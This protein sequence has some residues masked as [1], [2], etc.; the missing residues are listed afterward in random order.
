MDIL[1]FLGSAR[2]KGNTA[3]VLGWV[4]EE[5]RSLGHSVER[6]NLA[7]KKIS[8]CL[9]C[10]KCRRFPDRL[11]CVQEDDAP[12]ILE[13]QLSADA[14]IYASP[15]YFWGFS[16]QMKAL[17]DRGYCLVREYGLPG[18][19]SLVEGQRQA[20]LVT[21]A[22]A[23]EN[24]AELVVTS[25]RRIVDYAKARLAGELVVGN[26]TSPAELSQEVRERARRLA[27]ELVGQD[28]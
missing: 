1:T 19:A 26:C 16:A 15:L 8:G 2:K 22:D 20:L 18:H 21:A 12:A 3:T 17:I 25:F 24:N 9:G 11:G 28:V 10:A 27:R 4:E 23:Y 5:L 6:I 14:V 7:S 13:R